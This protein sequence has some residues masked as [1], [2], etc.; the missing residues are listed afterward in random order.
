MNDK[1]ILDSLM[2]A[3]VR[4][5]RPMIYEVVNECLSQQEKKDNP[6]PESDEL[7]TIEDV[8][9]YFGCAKTS[10]YKWRNQ[11]LIVSHRLGRKVYYKKDE[12]QKALIS[13]RS[14]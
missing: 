12:L 2:D 10:I 9:K 11:G 3:I 5:F 1:E 13:G 6:I 14:K 4:K 8:Q 7:W